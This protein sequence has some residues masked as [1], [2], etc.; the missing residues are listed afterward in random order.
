MNYSP[1]PLN[2]RVQKLLLEGFRRGSPLSEDQLNKV[3]KDLGKDENIFK[4]TNLDRDYVEFLTTYGSLRNSPF[5]IVGTRGNKESTTN[6]ASERK[7]KSMTKIQREFEDSFHVRK[8]KR[9][10]I[11]SC[12]WIATEYYEYDYYMDLSGK[13][14]SYVYSLS[15]GGTVKIYAENFLDFLDKFYLMHKWRDA[16]DVYV[17]NLFESH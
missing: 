14:K 4:L 8:F 7:I 10:Q 6:E 11:K 2:E 17:K 13:N 5:V 9:A 1:A 12:W 15:Y 16:E 3:I